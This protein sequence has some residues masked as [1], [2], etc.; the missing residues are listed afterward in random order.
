MC[1]CVCVHVCAY[2]CMLEREMVDKADSKFVKN[3]WVQKSVRFRMC[4]VWQGGKVRSTLAGQ[5]KKG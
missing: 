5:K 1:A 4:T 2:V 3:S